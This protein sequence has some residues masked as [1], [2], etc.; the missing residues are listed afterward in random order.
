MG[1]TAPQTQMQPVTMVAGC[2]AAKA[3]KSTTWT[4][5]TGATSRDSDGV[6]MAESS[7]LGSAPSASDGDPM[8][9]STSRQRV[10]VMNFM[11]ATMRR[12]PAA[13]ATTATTSAV[14]SAMIGP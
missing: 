8:A 14:A 11:T 3:T 9:K 7:W 2:G 1:T 12:A 6:S 10:A 13:T 5:G 4:L